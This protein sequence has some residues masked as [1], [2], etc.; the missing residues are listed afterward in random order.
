VAAAVAVLVLIAVVAIVA[1]LVLPGDDPPEPLSVGPVDLRRPVT[2]A[3]AVQQS[4]PPC[5]GGALEDPE[6]S[7][8]YAFGSDALT[9]R[10]LE[11]V[12][13]IRPDPARGRTA[14]GVEL[15]LTPADAT[16]FAA[17]TGRAAEAGRGG[18]P[19]AVMGMLV[20]GK[21][22]SAPAQVTDPITGGKVEITGP[23]TTFTQVYAE[24]IVRRLTGG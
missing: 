4:P 7:T 1:V 22:V 9:V 8:C 10:R 15:T 24:G 16:G 23:A 18:Q 11:H 21:L 17:L 14:W 20:G 5:T 12:A 19:A 13:A 6:Q 3:L 2:F